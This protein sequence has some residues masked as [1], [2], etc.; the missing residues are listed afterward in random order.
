MNAPADTIEVSTFNF[1]EQKIRTVAID[2]NPWFFAVDICEA[3]GLTNVTMAIRSLDA[4]E[5]TSIPDPSATGSGV[6]SS[7][8]VINETGLFR[9]LVRARSRAA[10]KLQKLILSNVILSKDR[11]I[12]MFHDLDIEDFDE[13]FVYAIQESETGRIKIGISK[14][15]ERRIKELQTA[16]SQKLKLLHYVP[17]PNR[18]HDERLAQARAPNH[19]RGEWYDIGAGIKRLD[20]SEGFPVGEDVT[21]ALARIMGPGY[22]EVTV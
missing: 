21:A 3:I 12:D 2:G 13:Y 4:D 7:V 16:N 20:E 15:P 1:G 6:N 9:K 14:D 10:R 18:F 19:V 22:S 8:N 17:A 11:I 5:W